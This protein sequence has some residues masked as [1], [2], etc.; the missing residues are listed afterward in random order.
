VASVLSKL[1]ALQVKRQGIMKEIAAG[2]GNRYQQI[3]PLHEAG[4][5]DVSWV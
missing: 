4:G 1:A 2:E 3:L 5:Y